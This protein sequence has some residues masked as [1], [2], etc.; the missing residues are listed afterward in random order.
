[1]IPRYREAQYRYVLEFMRDALSTGNARLFVCGLNGVGKT[2]TIHAAAE[3]CN[4]SEHIIWI[5]GMTLKNTEQLYVQVA[6]QLLGKKRRTIVAA[7]SEIAQYLNTNPRPRLLVIDEI[8][9]VVKP[10][11][12]RRIGNKVVRVMYNLFA[13]SELGLPFIGISNSIDL[14]EHM[15][16]RLK[17]RGEG[18][19]FNFPAYTSIELETILVDQFSLPSEA[20]A[21]LAKTVASTSADIRK[22][23]DLAKNLTNQGKTSVDDVMVALGKERPIRNTILR[24]PLAQREL[25]SA[26]LDFSRRN[27]KNPSGF[28]LETS[29]FIH[30]SSV[31]S[32]SDLCN[33]LLIQ[34]LIDQLN[35]APQF[36]QRTFMLHPRVLPSDIEATCPS[37]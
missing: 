32:L 11:S 4:A 30:P 15:P 27:I 3:A 1:M 12:L 26:F 37:K 8:D 35:D 13:W 33:Q 23:F 7:Q 19:Y 20:A 17:S 28:Q 9:F 22:A 2:M 10:K 18:C 24:L 34:G 36:H 5:N 31:S 29:P 6:S 14:T 25:L 16:C 21:Y